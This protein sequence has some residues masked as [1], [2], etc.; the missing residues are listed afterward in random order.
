MFTDVM[1]CCGVHQ[2]GVLNLCYEVVEV[3]KFVKQSVDN[4]T[5]NAEILSVDASQ[6]NHQ[7]QGNNQKQLYR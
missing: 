3:K 1:A 4:G 5:N 6:S 2:N 7:N